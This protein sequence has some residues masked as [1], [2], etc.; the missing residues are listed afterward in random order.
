MHARNGG[1]RRRVYSFSESAVSFYI[2]ELGVWRLICTALLRKGA[3]GGAVGFG[4]LFS[5]LLGNSKAVDAEVVTNA[6]DDEMSPTTIHDSCKDEVRAEVP[7]LS[8]RRQ[9][10]ES[11]ARN[12]EVWVVDEQST[13]NHG[14][15]HDC[16]VW[17]R[18]VGKMGQDDLSRHAPKDQ[19]HGQT[20]QYQVVVFE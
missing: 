13:S 7:Q 9:G 12:G 15:E 1:L 19:G 14:C 18:L 10:S 5:C 4:V 17:E 2:P 16:P 8:L 20:V 3:V 11:R 6:C